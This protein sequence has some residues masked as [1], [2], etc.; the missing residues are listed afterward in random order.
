LTELVEIQNEELKFFAALQGVDLDKDGTEDE[1]PVI[2]TE[3]EAKV[4]L[5][6]DP[7]TYKDLSEDEKQSMTEKMKHKHTNWSSDVRAK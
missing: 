3:V 7:E 5:F 1:A 4:P 6:G 2:K